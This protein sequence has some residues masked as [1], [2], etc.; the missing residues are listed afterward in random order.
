[1]R[2]INVIKL[3]K[4][5]SFFASLLLFLLSSFAWAEVTVLEPKATKFESDISDNLFV[6]TS[7]VTIK[8]EKRFPL[9]T[10]SSS[11]VEMSQENLRSSQ[12]LD[13]YEELED[14]FS[15]SSKDIPILTDPLEGYNR[16]IFAT[17][18]KRIFQF[19]VVI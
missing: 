15:G 4:Y 10:E 8:L 16:D 9:S 12:D 2:V 5:S 19:F 13:D 6:Q 1:M 11:S 18:R 7:E 3:G 14:P 17:S